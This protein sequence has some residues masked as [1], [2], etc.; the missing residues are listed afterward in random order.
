[1]KI[2][3]LFYIFLFASFYF[4][5]LASKSQHADDANKYHDLSGAD[6]SHLEGH[7]NPNDA[8]VNPHYGM[9]VSQLII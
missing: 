2:S 5:I 8:T 4:P 1:M 9:N 3:P 7:V 6:G